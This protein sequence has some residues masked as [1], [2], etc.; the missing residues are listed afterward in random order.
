MET[1]LINTEN[2]KTNESKKIFFEFTDK[3]N[4]K[5]PNENFVLP[6][7]SIYHLIYLL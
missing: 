6:N 1:I 4:L 7:S 5:N 2:I 3:L